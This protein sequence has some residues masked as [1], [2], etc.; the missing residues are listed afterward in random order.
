MIE[1]KVVGN[2]HIFL[3]V[4][5]MVMSSLAVYSLIVDGILLLRKE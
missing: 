1:E 5:G 3:L 2:I 4:M